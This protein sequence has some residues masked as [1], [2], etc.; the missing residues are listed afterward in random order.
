MQISS[1]T[2][3]FLLIQPTNLGIIHEYAFLDIKL[4]YRVTWVDNHKNQVYRL[5]ESSGKWY[6]QIY[7]IRA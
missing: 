5:N 6:I 2:N 4:F 1:L 3:D 7:I